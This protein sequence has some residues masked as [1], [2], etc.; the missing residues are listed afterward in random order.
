MNDI[1]DTIMVFTSRSPE[2][3]LSKGGRQANNYQ[4]FCRI[5]SAEASAEISALAVGCR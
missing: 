5:P 2:R 1:E 3:V 4:H